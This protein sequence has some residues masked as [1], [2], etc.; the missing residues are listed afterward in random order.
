MVTKNNTYRSIDSRLL[1][2]TIITFFLI[3]TM[4]YSQTNSDQ[5][6]E[7]PDIA[8]QNLIIGI[9]SGN[10][11]VMKSC[12]YFAG[13]YRIVDV[14]HELVEVMKNSESDELCQMLVWSLYQ[15]GEESCCEEMRN[16]IE[17]HSSETI[18]D[19]CNYLHNIKEFESAIAKQ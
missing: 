4:L 14:S 2:L 9:Q 17:N 11:G 3:S 1:G 16:I 8:I 5:R 18:R 19:F 7:L 15:I 13:K 12:I 10:D 6:I